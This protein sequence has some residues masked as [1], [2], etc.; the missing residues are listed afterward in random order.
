M[1]TD[2]GE[3]AGSASFQTLTED[4]ETVFGLFAEVMREPA[5]AQEKLDLV[6][7]Q[8][9]GGIARRNDDPNSIASR[10]FK[11]LIYGKDSPY[12]RTVEYTTLDNIAREDLQKFYQQYFYPNNMILGIVGDFEP[13]KMRSLIHL[14]LF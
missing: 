13:K 3:A 1:E 10:E 8:A 4:L 7:T 11:K 5:F 6:K 12:A 14:M 9:K 2:I